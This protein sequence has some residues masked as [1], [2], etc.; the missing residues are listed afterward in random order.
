MSY[1]TITPE[2]IASGLDEALQK[3]EAIID[4]VVAD[5]E[6]RDFENT[7]MPIDRIGDILGHAN[8]NYAFMGYVHPDEAVRAAGKDAEEKLQTFGVEMIFRDDLNTAV[9]EYAATDEAATLIDPS[10]FYSVRSVTP[11]PQIR[12]RS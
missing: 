12:F 3:A 8:A 5:T 7:L 9:N 1:T 10:V 11:F 4:E 6:H 2:A